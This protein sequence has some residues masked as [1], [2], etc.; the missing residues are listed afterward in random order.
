MM[1]TILLAYAVGVCGALHYLWLAKKANP[2]PYYYAMVLTLLIAIRARDWGRCWVVR[3][4]S[5]ANGP[6]GVAERTRH[7]PAPVAKARRRPR[8]A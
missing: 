3:L 4:T 5:A 8:R 7:P 6:R 2:S 1:R